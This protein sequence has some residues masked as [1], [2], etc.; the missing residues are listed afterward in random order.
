MMFC[1]LIDRDQ[2]ESRYGPTEQGDAALAA[3]LAKR[4][5]PKRANS[6]E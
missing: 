3:V 4:L 2:S 1:G 5:N 6:H